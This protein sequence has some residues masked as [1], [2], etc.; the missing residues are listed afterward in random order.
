V[1]EVCQFLYSFEQSFSLLALLLEKGRVLLLEDGQLL[2]NSVV[3]SCLLL[4]FPLKSGVVVQQLHELATKL[5]SRH[6]PHAELDS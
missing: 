4:P 1:I 3:G 5:L 6:L 2:S